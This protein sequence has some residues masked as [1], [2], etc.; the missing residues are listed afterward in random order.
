MNNDRA[1]K[2]ANARKYIDRALRDCSHPMY[3]ANDVEIA[4]KLQV[5]RLTVINIRKELEIEC[6]KNR[7]LNLLKGIDTSQNTIK[8][9]ASKYRLKYQ[10]TYQLTRAHGLQT[11]PDRRPI[12]ALIES[13]KNRKNTSRLFI[14]TVG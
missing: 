7:V 12:V 4:K 11:R 2:C 9:L 3:T 1:S 8:E 5:T 13:Q 14:A 6:R 10:N